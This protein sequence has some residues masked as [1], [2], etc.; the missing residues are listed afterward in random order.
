MNKQ[1]MFWQTYLNLENDLIELSKNIYI[2]DEILIHSTGCDVHQPCNTQLNVF[3]PHIADLLIRTCIEI[4]AISKELYFELGGEKTRGDASIRFDEDCLKQIDIICKSHKK[5]VLVVTP[6]FNL[7]KEEHY[8]LKPLKEAHKRQGT[9]WEKAYQAVKHDRYF[10]LNKATIKVL[11]D[12]MA[13][14]FLLNIYNR[15]INISSKFHEYSKLDMSFGS[16]IFSL[17]L[18][19]LTYIMGVVNGIKYNEPLQSSDSPYILKYTD[20]IY[21]EINKAEE[22]IINDKANYL[23]QQPEFNDPAFLEQIKESK[24]REKTVTGH[25][26]IPICEL[27]KF[28]LN[29]KIPANL[30]F[31]TRKQLL[32]SSSE[33][34]EF[35]SR[36]KYNKNP[37]EITEDNIQAEIDHLAFMIGMN[38]EHDLSKPKWYKAFNEGYCELVLD[39]GD[40]R[41]K[42]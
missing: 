39:K 1:E 25:R 4:E 41:Y 19:D 23:M 11:I 32:L 37:N 14:L 35:I 40:V 9:A 31:E 30:T 21:K 29:K 42:L 22:Q 24:E 15:N 2:T 7:T 10:S 27:F 20:D 6:L 26:M 36:N 12:A 5:I 33:W 16:K 17:K 8:A 3:S 28:R 18:P 38:F 13:A 34:N